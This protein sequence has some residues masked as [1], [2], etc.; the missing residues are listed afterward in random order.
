MPGR[1][2]FARAGGGFFPEK[3]ARTGANVFRH[4]V[5]ES[6]PRTAFEN[7]KS[8]MNKGLYATMKIALT[9]YVRK[10]CIFRNIFII[11]DGDNTQ[12]QSSDVN[13]SDREKK[14]ALFNSSATL[15]ALNDVRSP[16][17]IYTTMYSVLGPK[18]NGFQKAR[19]WAWLT[20][21]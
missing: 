8:C 6:S 5:N 17:T 12:N 16:S 1:A 11:F 18:I 2:F 9:G 19:V 21:R 3:V 13:I 14:N 20:N 15:A 7:I 10:S 4:G